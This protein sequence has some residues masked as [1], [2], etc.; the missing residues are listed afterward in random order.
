MKPL[1]SLPDIVAELREL[2]AEVDRLN[3][4]NEPVEPAKPLPAAAEGAEVHVP[5]ETTYTG[6]IVGTITARRGRRKGT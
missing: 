4:A 2:R 3:A 6:P 5:I 1:R